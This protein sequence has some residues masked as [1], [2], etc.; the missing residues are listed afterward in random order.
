MS[1]SAAR[2]THQPR[3]HTNRNATP[4]ASPGHALLS[5]PCALL[6]TTLL[7]TTSDILTILTGGRW[8]IG[9]KHPDLEQG[10]NGSEI[11]LKDSPQGGNGKYG[12][13]DDTCYGEFDGFVRAMFGF[14]I[15]NV[16][17]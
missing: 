10:G 12:R 11:A 1:P 3:A 2:S 17:I 16:Q 4:S 6:L 5:C 13:T 7:L 9:S 8:L 14:I 15:A